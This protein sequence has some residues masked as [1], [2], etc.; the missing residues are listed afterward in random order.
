M[1]GVAALVAY[2]LSRLFFWAPPDLYRI[3]EVMF[4]GAAVVAGIHLSLCAV[5]P[6]A[7]IELYD[8]NGQHISLNAIFVK[9][10]RGGFQKPRPPIKVVLGQIHFLHIFAAGFGTGF[11]SVG[12]VYKFCRKPGGKA[13]TTPP[14]SHSQPTSASALDVQATE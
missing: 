7:L 9:D 1:G 6:E 14:A 8:A 13:K 11:I 2:M 12:G 5:F 3:A 4:C 10:G